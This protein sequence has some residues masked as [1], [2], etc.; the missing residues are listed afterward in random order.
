MKKERG[1]L[2]NREEKRRGKL[3]KREGHKG[4]KGEGKTREQERKS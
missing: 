2:G 4:G 3:E 1:T